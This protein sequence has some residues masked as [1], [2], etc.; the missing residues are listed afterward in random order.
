MSILTS[1]RPPAP[2]PTAVL[3]APVNRLLSV[4]PAAV[5]QRIAPELAVV[6][7]TFKQRLHT[8]GETIHH[9]YFPGGGACS[10]MKVMS[11]GATVEI[12]TVGDE[13]MLGSCVY[14]GEDRSIGDAIVQ[15]EGGSGYQMSVAAFRAEMDRREDFHDLIV[16]YSQAMTSQVMQ[17]AA[18]NALHNVE[19]RCCRWLLITRDRI[20]SDELKLTQEF[21]SI[22]LGVRRPTV[23]LTIGNLEAAGIVT[24]QRGTI[25]I[26]DLGGLREASCECYAE[27]KANFARLMPEMSHPVG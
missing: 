25:S 2:S 21:L 7:L 1:P 18:C 23:T 24:T 16:R 22:M 14:F 17:T 5:L 13:G 9:V 26:V 11:D 8:Q 27:A 12:A 4:L 20:R 3:V 6:P 10:L 19:Q 15:I